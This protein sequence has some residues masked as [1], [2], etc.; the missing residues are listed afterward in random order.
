MKR[1]Q[2]TSHLPTFPRLLSYITHQPLRLTAAV[3]FLVL[4]ALIQATQPV[5]FGVAVDELASGDSGNAVRYGLGIMVLAVT[6]GALSF[7]A[8]RQ[9]AILAQRA[10]EE[11]RNELFTKMQTLS[12]S[13]Y[14]AESAG[15]LN[16][17]VTSDTEVVN[18]FFTAAIGRIIT[19]F[20]TVLAMLVLMLTLD[21]TM[22]LVVVLIVPMS[23]GVFVVLG[24]RIQADF[25][26]YQQLVGELNGYVEEIVE[27]HRTVTA[28][29]RQT[30]AVERVRELSEEAR[31][32]DRSAQ[33]RSYLM[34][35][36]NTLSNNLDV[37]LV[38][39]IGGSR[40]VS[41]TISL[42]D[43]VSFVGYA[44][45]FG[46]Q[47]NQLSQVVTQVLSAAAGGRRVFEIL[48][49]EPD[50]TTAEGAESM[51]E[52]E[53][54][55]EFD[56]VDFSYL[57][58]KQILFDNDFRVAPG[59]FIGL[60]GPT[61]AGK[62]TIINLL[63]RFYDIDAGDIRLDDHS[64][65]GIDLDDLR[66]RCGVVLQ[67][68]FLF[69]ESVMYN[70]AYG[71]E[72]VTE[73]ECI[74]A[75]KAAEAHRFIERLPDGY[76]TVLTGGAVALSQGQRQLLT[77]ARAIVSE[78]DVLV[79]DEA[80][81]S[82]DTRT[83]RRIQTALDRLMEGRTSFVIAHRLATVRNADKIIVLD[84][85]RIEEI[86]SHDEL[87]AAE[88]FYASMY[89]QQFAGANGTMANGAPATGTSASGTPAGGDLA[90]SEAVGSADDG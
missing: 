79:L 67:T 35:P 42:G 14:D 1:H 15:D 62:S 31:R 59:Q 26:A 2:R 21:A 30:D 77:I 5:L 54:K 53:G 85:G 38:A 46:G 90:A 68:P 17:R 18:Q 10:M 74:E 56:H 81:S 48:D 51:A 60:V 39:L 34:Q 22:T 75:A 63:T 20:M 82:V 73:E 44:Q 72:G 86:G 4:G 36:V 83:E 11:L 7:V 9:L 19:T 16:A 32:A 69:S 45:Q 52:A 12:L 43:V 70:L 76:D 55:V 13:F 27:G 3:V 40:A 65:T 64:I 6:S 47:A 41:G 37:A 25:S 50:I 57:P 66:R 78:P 28:Y 88:G 58:G 33:F 61:G 23:F 89:L 24:R 8:N 87:M 71:R 29:G 49:R 84:A 80:T